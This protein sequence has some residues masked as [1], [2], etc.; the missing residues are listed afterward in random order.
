MAD[1]ALDM[2]CVAAAVPVYAEK[3]QQP[4][5]RVR[6]AYKMMDSDNNGSIS[7]EE[8]M[9]GFKSELGEA[10]AQHVVEWIDT[11]FEKHGT[12]IGNGTK[13]LSIKVFM[14]FY[15]GVLFAHFDKDNSGTLEL[16]EVQK[17]LAFLVK[18]DAAGEKTAPVV[19][20][21]AEFQQAGGEV[22]LPFAWFWATFKSMD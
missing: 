15:A 18:P 2:T 21:P 22:S 9:A 3:R 10:P 5:G 1:A 11:N 16:A 8:L 17:A 12:D 19:S 6:H 7:K 20:F 4:P 14:R 13:E